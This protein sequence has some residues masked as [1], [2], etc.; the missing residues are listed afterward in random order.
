MRNPNTL[1]PARL[2][3]GVA[4]LAAGAIACTGKGS[5]TPPETTAN[6][7]VEGP[8]ACTKII[9]TPLG[10]ANHTVKFVLETNNEEKPGSWNVDHAEYTFGDGASARGNLSI[11]HDY[12]RAG[13]FPVNAEVVLDVAPGL[14]PPVKGNTLGCPPVTVEVS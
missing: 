10:G 2:M 8:P 12:P 4:L 9:P 11:T 3:P 6:K 1:R 13:S 14:S 5:P 7:P